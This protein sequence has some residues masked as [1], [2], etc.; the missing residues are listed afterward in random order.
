MVDKRIRKIV[1][2]GILSNTYLKSF[3]DNWPARATLC[4]L[5]TI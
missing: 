4:I 5:L 3:L 1:Q 2:I